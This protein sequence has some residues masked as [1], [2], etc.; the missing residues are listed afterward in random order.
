MV[1]KQH[2]VRAL[3]LPNCPFCNG[4]VYYDKWLTHRIFQM[5]CNECK[6]HWRTGISNN[7]EREMFVE[8]VSSKN[9]SISNEYFQKQ[10]T[11]QYWQEMIRKK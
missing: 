8:L 6:S 4:V 10:L 5:E 3:E 9:Q 2:N 1:E 11:L 7:T